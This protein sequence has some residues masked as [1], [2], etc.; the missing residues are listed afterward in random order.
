MGGEKPDAIT[1]VERLKDRQAVEARL[2]GSDIMR[3]SEPV[4]VNCSSG[5]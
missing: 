3:S 5:C 4:W 1:G 2:Q